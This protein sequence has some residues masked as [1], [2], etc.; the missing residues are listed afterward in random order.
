MIA[1][2][3]RRIAAAGAVLLVAAFAP[4]AA[5]VEVQRIEADGIEA[6]L[7]EDRTNP[8]ITVAF[9]FRGGAALDP[10]G[11]EGLAA[12]TAALLDEGAGGLD[13]QAFQRRLEDL[14]IRLGFD[15]AA[16]TV[17][18]SL[19][20]LS[21]HRDAAFDLLRLALTRPRFDAEPV[22]RVRSQMEARLRETAEDPDTLAHERL[23]AALFPD[24]P[25]GRPTGG[26]PAGVAAIGV[27]DL[28][29]FVAQRFARDNLVIGVV[30]DVAPDDLARLLRDTFAALP[31][32]AAPA[33]V[34]EVRPAATGA[35]LIVDTPARQSAIAF[36]Q[37]G[38]KRD[39]PDFYAATVLNHVLGAGSFTSRLFA[40]VRERRGLAYTVRTSL[41]PF[42]HAGLIVGSAGT[43][44]ERAAETVAVIRDEW[45]RLAE[46]GVSADELA[47][48]KTYLTGS[49]P[50]RFTSGGR[51]ARILVAMQL[52]HLGI[53]F[54]DRR[55][56]LIEAVTLDDVNRLARTLLDP[57]A[58]TFVVAG[59]PDG[60]AVSE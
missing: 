21:E 52:D 23:S 20:T 29:A 9:A 3:V 25:Y 14:A 26:T 56:G 34:A 7:V 2:L 36:A 49:F 38:L 12:M 27:D 17:G 32:T 10:A 33:A 50:L 48:S 60:L 47:D 57:A 41:V 42:A 53:D 54:L 28:R 8:I 46:E 24:H 31:A 59:R 11:R 44:N 16:D 13:S 5:A 1:R 18:G 22:A 19:R 40:E 58:L 30:G 51:I 35:T 39:D 37:P 55:N 45:R 6:W 15:A 43:A 4:A